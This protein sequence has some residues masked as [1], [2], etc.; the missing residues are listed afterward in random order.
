MIIAGRNKVTCNFTATTHIGSDTLIE[1]MFLEN[2][3]Q[4][5]HIRIQVSVC[6]ISIFF[7]ITLAVSS[8]HSL[9]IHI[10]K[11]HSIRHCR[12]F[13]RS[14]HTRFHF[15]GDFRLTFRTTFCF[16]QYNTVCT[17]YTIKSSSSSIFQ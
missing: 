5:V 2:R 7:N 6:M 10:G 14:Y 4:P 9:I 13:G 8:R 16:N 15:D 1:R 12:D 3:L 17:A 11:I